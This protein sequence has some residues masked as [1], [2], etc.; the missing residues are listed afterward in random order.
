MNWLGINESTIRTMA[1]PKCYS[2][3]EYAVPVWSRSRH[4]RPK[5]KQC[6]CSCHMM[7]QTN[8]CRILYL[9][10]GIAPPD[11]RKVYVLEWKEPNR[12]NMRITPCV[13]SSKIELG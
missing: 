8:L 6:M 9:L 11:I 5:P 7:P 3:A 12:R 10:A 4:T 13:V 1:L 2:L